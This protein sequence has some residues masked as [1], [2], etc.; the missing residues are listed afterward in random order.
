MLHILWTEHSTHGRMFVSHVTSASP[1][2]TR[3][4][5]KEKKHTHT[6]FDCTESGATR[7]YVIFAKST[8]LSLVNDHFTSDIA[9]SRYS[10]HVI[11]KRG[12]KKS[13]LRYR[14][15]GGRDELLSKL[16]QVRLRERQVK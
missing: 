5:K 1:I 12:T 10:R 13:H 4:E 14:T 3:I 9:N 16:G 2:L 11:E 6:F 7:F 15:G 8:L